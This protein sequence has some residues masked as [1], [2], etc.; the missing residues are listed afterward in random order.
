MPTMSNCV[1]GIDLGASAM[2]ACVL[3][4][5]SLQIIAT[6]S[7]QITTTFPQQ[8]YAEQDAHQWITAFVSVCQQL[9]P[10]WQHHTPHMLSISA[11]THSVVPVN[12]AFEPIAAAIMWNDQRSIAQTN[13]LT[14]LQQQAIIAA[15]FNRCAPTWTV[16][17]LRWYGEHQPDIIADAVYFLAPKDFLKLWCTGELSTDPSDATGTLL[18]NF[19]DLT[20]N[21]DCIALAGIQRSQL[22][23]IQHATTVNA[24]IHNN[25]AHATG[26]PQQLAV[27]VGAIDTN[28]ELISAGCITAGDTVFKLASAGVVS[29]LNNAAKPLPPLSCYPFYFSAGDT[30]MGY[31]A[32]GTNTCM[33][34]LAWMRNLFGVGIDQANTIAAAAP[35]G[36]NDLLFYPYLLGERAPLWDSNATGGWVG[37][38]ITHTQAD[39]VRAVYEGVACSLYHIT[40]SYQLPIQSMRIVGGGSASALLCQI[41]VDICGVDATVPIHNDASVGSALLALAAA[42]LA[43]PA[44][45]T[46]SQ[47]T[48]WQEIAARFQTVHPAL[49]YTSNSAH[50]RQY[51]AIYARYQQ[52]AAAV[53][54]AH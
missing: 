34:S 41:L 25:A 21:D 18:R 27:C 3:N 29:Q 39:M 36:S 42:K 19:S 54:A 35:V 15:T 28:V 49:A 7:H 1:I 13:N 14:N 24:T 2:K 44:H 31:Y 23:T 26:L 43:T 20:W 30:N 40:N 8:W 6:A 47:A 16:S 4:A 48:P 52:H 17:M 10:L 12:A 46:Q 51:Q 9:Q 37:L 22:P 11:G 32:G 50:H 5:N 33:G 53:A 38:R 45:T